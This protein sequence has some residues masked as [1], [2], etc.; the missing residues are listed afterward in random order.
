MIQKYH[1]EDEHNW[2]ESLEYL[3]Y[4]V[5]ET[6]QEQ[7]KT[8]VRYLYPLGIIIMLLTGKQS[9]QTA[10]NKSFVHRNT[11]ASLIKC[12]INDNINMREGLYRSDI[13]IVSKIISQDNLI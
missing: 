9:E 4:A 2:E 5:W 3:M 12:T 8:L 6:K 11:E 13:S 10:T 7:A 1:Y